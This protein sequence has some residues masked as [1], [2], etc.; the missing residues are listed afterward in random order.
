MTELGEL[1]ELLYLARTRWRTVRLAMTD[2][3]HLDRQQD[4][5]ERSLQLEGTSPPH[6]WGEIEAASRTWA[7]TGGRFRQERDGTTLVHDGVRTW[8]ATPESG[9]VE[10]ETEVIRPIGDELLDPAAFLPGFDFR[11]AGAAEAARRPVL[12]VTAVP[13]PRGAG[14]VDLFPQGADALSLSVDRE[15]GVVLRFE[16]SAAGLP[17]RRLEVT[18]IAFDEPFGD[19]LFTP[20]P[21]EA[22]SV[23][24]A[25]STVT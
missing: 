5:Y 8:I 25:S 2:W 3:T 6:S 24:A 9:V 20:P 11:V 10:H 15:R 16:A 17:I 19:G 7:E 12:A 22:R 18:E 1:L 23:R 13:R 4:A 21:G 14:P